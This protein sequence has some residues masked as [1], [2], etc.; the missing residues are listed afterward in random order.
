MSEV[1]LYR[2]HLSFNNLCSSCCSQQRA[3]ALSSFMSAYNWG[4]RGTSLIR[5]TPP[6]GPFSRTKPR[7]L[8]W[9]KGGRLFLMSKVSLCTK[10]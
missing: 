8:W 7:A 3:T 6:P 2:G 4:Y 10:E 5:N 9:S 1:S